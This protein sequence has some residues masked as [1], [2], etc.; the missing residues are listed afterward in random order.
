VVASVKLSDELA[1]FGLV[2][3]ARGVVYNLDPSVSEYVHQTFQGG[4]GLAGLANHTVSTDVVM[5]QQVPIVHRVSG[6]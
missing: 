5:A 2:S 6:R 3:Q 1:D 4:C